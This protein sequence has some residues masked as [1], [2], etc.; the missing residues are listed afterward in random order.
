MVS[1]ADRAATLEKCCEE[2]AV[3]K[4]DKVHYVKWYMLYHIMFTV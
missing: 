4:Y 3:T 2:F 1:L